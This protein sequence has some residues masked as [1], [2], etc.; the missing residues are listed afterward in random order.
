VTRPRTALVLGSLL[1]SAAAPA[2]GG[3]LPADVCP[4]RYEA[5]AGPLP[6]GTQG[7]QPADFGTIPEAC[8]GSDLSLRLRG[9]VAVH[10][11]AP[12]FSGDIVA[13]GTL[14]GRRRLNGRSWVSLSVDVLTYRYFN[15]GGLVG[16]GT[17][18]GPAALGLHE[19]LRATPRTALAGYLRVLLP[20][21]TARQSGL[22]TGLELGAAARARPSRRW[23]FDGG[24]SL[25]GPL[26]VTAGVAHGRLEP[27]ALAEA[28]FSPKTSFALFGGGAVQIEAAPAY[29]LVAVTP[30]LGLRAALRH[31]LWLGFLAEAPLG[32]TE[33]TQAIASLFVGWIP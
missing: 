18:F 3:D 1:L 8:A 6:G 16:T 30:R 21:D 27:G 25:A 7:E 10:S 24:V 26:V 23:A 12:D 28:W 17:S 9:E 29:A 32:V 4:G 31:G 14:R 11:G 15:N 33:P 5:A 2:R 13:G 22:E 20:I 19:V